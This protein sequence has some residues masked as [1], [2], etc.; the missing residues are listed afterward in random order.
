MWKKSG[1]LLVLA[2]V[3]G[4]VGLALGVLVEPA[5]FA[6]FGSMVVLFG[7]MSEYA[8]LHGELNLLYQRLHKVEADDDMP[9]LMPSKWHLKKVRFSHLTVI[10][11]TFIWGFGDLLI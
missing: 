2:W 4:L 1:L 8:L 11:G 5:L 10:I 6:R 7:A 9:D 3:M